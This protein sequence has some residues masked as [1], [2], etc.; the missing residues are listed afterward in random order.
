MLDKDELGAADIPHALP[1]VIRFVLQANCQRLI[2]RTERIRR[3]WTSQHMRQV[4]L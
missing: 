1:W 3:V 4:D 2:S